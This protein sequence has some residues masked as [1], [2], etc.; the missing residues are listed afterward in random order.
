MYEI[1]GANAD[2]MPLPEQP[3]YNTLL[4][5]RLER[6]PVG[7]IARNIAHGTD[8]FA[9]ASQSQIDLR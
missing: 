3:M 8:I 1:P 9:V 7:G 4:Q 5:C 2:V 6:W